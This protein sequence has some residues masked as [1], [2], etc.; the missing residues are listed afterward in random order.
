MTEDLKPNDQD[1]DEESD[2][3]MEDMLRMM[4]EGAS[5]EGENELGALSA[6][7]I[8]R[9]M[10]EEAE[11][12]EPKHEE[13]LSEVSPVEFPQLGP[14]RAPGEVGNLDRLMNVNLTVSVEL[15]RTHMTLR[16]LMSLGESSL[17]ELQDRMA[18]EAVDILVNGRLFARGEVVVMSGENF[19]VRITELLPPVS[20]SEG[21]EES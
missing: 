14:S 2:P 16:D 5:E 1:S 17:I 4:A 3:A 13:Q 20:M 6:D 7:E 12:V 21:S 8:D 18:G 10:E 19:G 9:L 11:E 15:G